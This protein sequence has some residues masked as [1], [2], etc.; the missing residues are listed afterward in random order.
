MFK[1]TANEIKKKEDKE[2]EDPQ[3]AE[4][5]KR[6]K[7][8]VDKEALDARLGIPEGVDSLLA[9]DGSGGK[10]CGDGVDPGRLEDLQQV[11]VVDAASFFDQVDSLQ[12][13]RAD[14][15]TRPEGKEGRI[16]PRY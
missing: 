3:R 11:V 10:L 14:K 4:R 15:N 12:V 9:A 2:D 5:R 13:G 8:E 7:E 6:E 16:H 1:Y